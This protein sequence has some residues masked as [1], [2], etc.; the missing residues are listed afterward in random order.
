[1]SFCIH[2]QRDGLAVSVLTKICMLLL[3]RERASCRRTSCVSV[4][5]G[6]ACWMEKDALRSIKDGAGFYFTTSIQPFRSRRRQTGRA[7]MARFHNIM[8]YCVFILFV[9]EECDIP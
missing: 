4:W 8:W 9:L 2:I 5:T 6:T 7:L 3:L 1:M